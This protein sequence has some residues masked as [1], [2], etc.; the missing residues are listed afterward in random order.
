MKPFR[1]SSFAAGLCSLWLAVPA[2]FGQ[3]TVFTYQGQL[4]VGGSPANGLY[5]FQFQAYDA[6][7]SGNT[8]GPMF[9]TNGVPVTNG[10]FFVPID[11]GSSVFTG[12]RRWLQISVRTNNTVTFSTLTLQELTP[13]PYSIFAEGA[14]A[15]GLSGVLGNSQLA[16]NS[17]TVNAG[18]GLSGGGVAVPLGGSVTL[19]N[20]GVLSVTGNADIIA[21]TV[22]GV[23]TLNDTA[24]SANTAST[25]VARDGSGNFMA[26]SVALLGNLSA[27]SA[28]LTNV[29]LSGALTLPA[30]TDTIYTGGSGE[31]L[32][33]TDGNNNFYSGQN[34]GNLRLESFTWPRRGRGQH[35]PRRRGA[36]LQHFWQRQHGQRDLRALAKHQRQQQHSHRGRGPLLQHWRQ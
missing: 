13:Y 10:L 27:A 24:S 12:P 30:T 28:S 5:D 35:R 21:T 2:T 4:G 20:A 33:H 19:N 8:V 16:N 14:N 7:S 9:A 25:I 1:L 23:V 34:A 32:L 31:T 17:I 26:G 15:A 18:P 22:N 3:G 29:T 11:L 36:Q 6:A